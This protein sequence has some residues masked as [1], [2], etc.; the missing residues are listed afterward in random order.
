[1]TTYEKMTTTL[2]RKSRPEVVLRLLIATSF[3]QSV[4]ADLTFEIAKQVN[5]SSSEELELIATGLKEVENKFDMT[6]FIRCVDI[7]RRDGLITITVNCWNF[8]PYARTINDNA[9]NHEF[10]AASKVVL[11]DCDQVL[12]DPQLLASKLISLF[13]KSKVKSQSN[14]NLLIRNWSLQ[15]KPINNSKDTKGIETISIQEAIQLI[16]NSLTKK[17]FNVKVTTS[18]ILL[19]DQKRRLYNFKKI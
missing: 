7:K 10:L 9:D 8:D 16:A 19:L 3:P 14:E 5:Q 15:S 4:L 2:D 13:F 1:M 11:E 6:D 18:A 12:N 17:R